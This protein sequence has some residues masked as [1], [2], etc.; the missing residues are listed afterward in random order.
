[1]GLFPRLFGLKKSG[2]PS[3]L[4]SEANRYF[5]ALQGQPKAQRPGVIDLRS[6]RERAIIQD[7]QSGT[8]VGPEFEQLVSE[9]LSIKGLDTSK[10]VRQIGIQLHTAG[11]KELMQAAFYRVSFRG[12][13][14]SALSICWNGTGECQH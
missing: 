4:S 11:G 9:L 7:A 14:A 1:M 6:D 5:S 3:E 8:V 13:D 12:G 2:S 10:R